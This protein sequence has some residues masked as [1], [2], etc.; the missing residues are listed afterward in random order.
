MQKKLFLN[1]D[2]DAQ[3]TVKQHFYEARAFRL[4]LVEVLEKELESLYGSLRSESMYD[5]AGWEAKMADTLGQIKA[6]K[7][8]IDLIKL[9][10][11]GK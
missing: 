6:T 5:V 8:V 10:K 11:E 2:K 3:A 7:R 9:D 4:D 1:K